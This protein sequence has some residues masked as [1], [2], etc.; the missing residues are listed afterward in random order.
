MSKLVA[1]STPAERRRGCI[2]A[3][4]FVNQAEVEAN[5]GTLTGTPTINNGA[6]FNG[7]TDFITYNSSD[8]DWSAYTNL[9][10]VIEFE[11]DFA[12]DGALHNFIQN[13]DYSMVKFTND[14]LISE[15]GGSVNMA[16]SPYATYG[17]YWNENGRNVI[18]LSATSGNNELFLNGVSISADTADAWTPTEQTNLAVGAT[19][20]GAGKYVG[21]INKIRVFNTKLTLQE[22]TD[23]Y[24]NATYGYRNQQV[25]HLPMRMEDHDPTNSRTLDVS[26]GGFH[27]TFGAGAATPTKLPSHGYGCGGNDYMNFGAALPN[28]G[29]HTIAALIKN[30]PDI[31]ALQRI[32]TSYPGGPQT[33][34]L[35]ISTGTVVYAL[36]DGTDNIN[37]TGTMAANTAQTVIGTMASDKTM[38]LYLNGEQVDTD[39]YLYDL[40]FN[41][42]D[43]GRLEGVDIQY[44]IG[45]ILDVQM[46]TFELTPLQVKD[47]HLRLFKQVN[48]V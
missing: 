13:A 12:D 32:V 28:S 47:L 22:A 15:L 9:S 14:A 25:V 43:I 1:N 24:N 33:N 42:W 20:G 40:V 3:E 7:T 21:T 44:I 26:G 19:T 41:S 11:P 37:I 38:K 6:T 17:T 2:F 39:T 36:T 30:V 27:A 46:W 5:G 23:Y 16:V 8:V 45:D 34:G 31:T 48:N 35:Y 10:I 29:G 18:V 4:N